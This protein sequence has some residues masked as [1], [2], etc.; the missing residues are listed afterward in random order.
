MADAVTFSVVPVERF[1]GKSA[2]LKRPQVDNNFRNDIH[3]ILTTGFR[4]LHVSHMTVI[5]TFIGMIALFSTIGR[6]LFLQTWA[7]VMRHS[8][9]MMTVLMNI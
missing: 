4:K 7:E 6:L 2:P 5:A 3:D 1:A 8:K 9:D